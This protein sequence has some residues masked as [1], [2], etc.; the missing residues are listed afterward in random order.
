MPFHTVNLILTPLLWCPLPDQHFVFLSLFQ[1]SLTF[2]YLDASRVRLPRVIE[3][4]W[5][6]DQEFS[7]WFLF[8]TWGIPFDTGWLTESH[9][10]VQRRVKLMVWTDYQ[11]YSDRDVQFKGPDMDFQTER[12][13]RRVV[14][15]DHKMSICKDFLIFQLFWWQLS[16]W[17]WSLS[18]W[19]WRPI[20]AGT[21][22]YFIIHNESTILHWFLFHQNQAA[23]TFVLFTGGVAHQHLLRSF[24]AKAHSTQWIM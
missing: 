6:V 8:V 23:Q 7:I 5:W 18:Y 22:M 10:G 14:Q 12:L 15:S 17:P 24:A 19:L 2:S 1:C 3:K 16:Y 4:S 21:H 11:A 13:W 20:S 9:K